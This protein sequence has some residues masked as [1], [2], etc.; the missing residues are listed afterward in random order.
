MRQR[1]ARLI[2]GGWPLV[3]LVWAGVV[4][5]LAVAAPSFREVAIFDDAAYLPADSPVERGR[6]MMVE[7]WPEKGMARSVTVA[8]VREGRPLGEGDAQALRHVRRWLTRQS[9]PGLFGTVI[10]PLG[11]DGR[12]SLA[13]A[14]GHAWLLTAEM[15][16]VPYS[17][18][19]VEALQALRRVADRAEAP[20]G[21]QR[22]VTG[23]PAVAIDEQQAVEAGVQ[24]TRLLSVGLVVALLLFIL[25]SPVAALVPLLTVGTAYVVTLRIVSALGALGLDV[26][27]LFETF[28]IVIIFG[29][30]TDYSLMLM[31]RF[32]EELAA[33]GQGVA[34]SSGSRGRRATLTVTLAVLLGALA[35]AAAST[36]VGF[37]AQ[38]VA[39]FGLFR[40]MGPAMAI[41][42]AITLVAG[43][44]LTPALMRLAGPAL[45]WPRRDRAQRGAA[46]YGG[47]APAASQPAPPA[48]AG[49]PP[50]HPWRPPAGGDRR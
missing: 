33:R 24:R 12:A 21:L 20:P 44:T 29:A 18:E 5:V 26:S 31:T 4:A 43:L 11:A 17:P 9:P 38:S 25:R 32:R 40:T 28:A 7:G 49:T 42:V 2:V 47:A 35:S 23:T 45:F 37:G 22:Y 34:R 41:A 13:S 48:R 50:G 6:R 19:G 27:H 8:F 36:M 30:G 39:E 1:L 3:L 10:S 46:G 16:T 15:T 14:D